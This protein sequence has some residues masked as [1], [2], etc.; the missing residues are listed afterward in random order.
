MVHFG[1]RRGAASGPHEPEQTQHIWRRSK[2]KESAASLRS[3]P[4][5]PRPEKEHKLKPFRSTLASSRL[6]FYTLHCMWPK[7]SH[8]P[9]EKQNKKKKKTGYVVHAEARNSGWCQKRSRALPRPFQRMSFPLHCGHWERARGCGSLSKYQ[10]TEQTYN[11][12]LGP[13][14][15]GR[16]EENSKEELKGL[17]QYIQ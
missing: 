12:K 8:K 3:Q 14:L 16:G 6:P 5:I 2:E 11:W 1:R 17:Q 4:G 7:E 9:L 10:I 13:D 15:T